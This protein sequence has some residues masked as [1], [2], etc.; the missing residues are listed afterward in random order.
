MV[1]RIM[2]FKLSD[3]ESRRDV[4]ERVRAALYDLD[5]AEE[6]SVGLPADPASEKSWDL[7]VV[8]RFSTLLRQNE[9][10]ESSTFRKFLGVEM[11]GRY[12]VVKAWSFERLA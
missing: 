4:A 9:A 5:G 1:E 12:E 7:C 2:L 10:L 8:L 3:P 6:L 11:Q